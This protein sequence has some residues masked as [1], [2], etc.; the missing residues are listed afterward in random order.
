MNTLLLGKPEKGRMVE[1]LI[2]K[3][4]TG[5]QICSKIGEADL[6]QL[7]ENINSKTQSKSTVKFDRRR[8]ALDSD[9]EF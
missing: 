8:A 5:G 2:L 6:I 7:L 1:N 4:A 9:D 3:M